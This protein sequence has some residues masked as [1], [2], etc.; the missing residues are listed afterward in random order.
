VALQPA[1]S[2]SYSD[3]IFFSRLSLPSGNSKQQTVEWVIVI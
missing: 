1:L 2:P 3:C